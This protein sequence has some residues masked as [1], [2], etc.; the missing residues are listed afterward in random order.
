MVVQQGVAELVPDQP[1]VGGYPDRTACPGEPV[2]ELLHPGAGRIADREGIHLVA[3]PL[4][5]DRDR[6]GGAVEVPVG[7]RESHSLKQCGRPRRS[8]GRRWRR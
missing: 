4:M 5:V 8:G 7:D 2:D 6:E 3:D 1:H